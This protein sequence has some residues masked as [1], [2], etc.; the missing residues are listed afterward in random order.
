[1][2]DNILSDLMRAGVFVNWRKSVLTPCKCLRFLGM[3]VDSVA[4]KFFVPA[5]KVEKLQALVRDVTDGNQPELSFRQLASILGKVMPMQIA[6]SAVKMLTKECYA[7]LRPGDNW[8]AQA[9]LTEAV[10][11]ELAEVVRWIDQFD[12]VGNP[13]R[14][15]VGM[16]ELRII[17]DSGTGYGWRIDGKGRSLQ[18]TD[19]MKAES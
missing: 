16:E 19:S 5:D 17:V 12:A 6:V 8:E 10:L 4:Y 15:Y 14:R 18:L 7:A 3:L 9:L 13:V 1:M 11:E 2:R